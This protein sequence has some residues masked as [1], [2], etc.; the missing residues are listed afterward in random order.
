MASCFSSSFWLLSVDSASSVNDPWE[1]LIIF[2][3]LWNHGSCKLVFFSIWNAVIFFQVMWIFSLVVLKLP[4]R[5]PSNS[6]FL[7]VPILVKDGARQPGP[8]C[9]PLSCPSMSMCELT[10]LFS[11][12]CV[13]SLSRA[14][15]KQKCSPLRETTDMRNSGLENT[16]ELQCPILKI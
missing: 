13:Q 7:D 9:V 8:S 4:N 16:L 15:I 11:L 12:L 6:F 5:S 1:K 2:L 10:K 14:A 3:Q